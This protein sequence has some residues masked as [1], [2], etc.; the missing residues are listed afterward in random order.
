[1][2]CFGEETREIGML[3]AFIAGYYYHIFQN[4]VHFSV[5]VMDCLY[6]GNQ[7]SHERKLTFGLLEKVMHP[8]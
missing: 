3:L 5:A 2:V 7:K 1:M 4:N 6:Q 8:R